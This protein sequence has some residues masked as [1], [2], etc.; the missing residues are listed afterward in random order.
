MT[1]PPD[2]DPVLAAAVDKLAG[3]LGWTREQLLAMALLSYTQLVDAASEGDT[4]VVD[5][6]LL[7]EH[8]RKCIERVYQ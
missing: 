5:L 2:M 6:R 7:R 1:D 8:L 4:A 3:Q